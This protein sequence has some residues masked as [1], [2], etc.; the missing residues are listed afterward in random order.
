MPFYGKKWWSFLAIFI[1]I[2]A[3]A[4]IAGDYF[5]VVSKVYDVTSFVPENYRILYTDSKLADLDG[6]IFGV[7][8]PIEQ[9]NQ[10][11]RNVFLTLQRLVGKPFFR[12]YKINLERECP[13]WAM[14][15]LC[16]FQGKCD[17]CECQEDEVP[18]FW[19]K[20]KEVT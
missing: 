5:Q 8:A 7:C 14:Q 6:E 11:N 10:I 16:G 12:T 20:N 3:T 18:A 13:F 9:L 17:V 19:K 4:F 1:G 15:K 2:S